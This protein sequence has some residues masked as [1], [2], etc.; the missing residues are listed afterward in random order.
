MIL[1]P[2]EWDEC[3]PRELE[4]LGD[5]MKELCDIMEELGDIME[6]LGDIMEEP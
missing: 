3:D 2:I 5:I 4:H 1:Y 6:E